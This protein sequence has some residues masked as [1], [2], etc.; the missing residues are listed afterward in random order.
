MSNN[1]DS[2][3]QDPDSGR[4]VYEQRRG[5]DELGRPFLGQDDELERTRLLNVLL[6]ENDIANEPR[7]AG[8][9]WRADLVDKIWEDMDGF[10]L[11]EM[12]ELGTGPNERDYDEIMEWIDENIK[13]DNY[14][15]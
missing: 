3:I 12:P 10:S 14:H 6:C 9:D 7:F 11:D 15:E 2:V 1:Y 13:G 8:V 4:M 5:R